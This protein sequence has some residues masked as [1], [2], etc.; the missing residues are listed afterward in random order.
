MCC[1]IAV[2]QLGLKLYFYNS[3]LF[4]L[5]IAK[6][7]I[8]T[9]NHQ[10]NFFVVKKVINHKQFYVCMIVSYFIFLPCPVELKDQPFI[11]SMDVEH[12]WILRQE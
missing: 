4:L 7:E 5:R 11:A 10:K 9:T 8:I 6:I 3:V 1:N 12:T 2:W